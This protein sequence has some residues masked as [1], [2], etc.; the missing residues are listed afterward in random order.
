MTLDQAVALSLL[1]N[2]PRRGLTDRLRAGDPELMERAA[3]LLGLARDARERAAR[4]SI[5]V[6]AWDDER[7]PAGLVAI[8]DCPPALWYR[9]NLGCLGAVAVAIVGSRAASHVSLETASRLAA[10]LASRGVVVVSGLARGVDSAAHR[11]AL[12]TGS[13]IAVLGSG[14]DHVY[15]AEHTA[16]AREIETTGLVLSEYPPG[17]GPLPFR[18]PMRN[19]LI[20][21]LS[22]AVVVI[23]AHEKSGSLITAACAMDQ[24][25]DVMAVPGTVLGGRNRGG[26]SLIR[27]GAKIVECADDILNELGVIPGGAGPLA[28]DAT[29][30]ART[31]SADPVLRRMDPG[32]PYDLDTLADASGLD[33]SRLLTRLVD[34]ELRG[35]IRRVGGGCFMRP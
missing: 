35:L 32:H 5:H 17:T 21:G 8:N 31:V 16:L 34:L 26:H 9:G 11:G 3:P 19:R 2:L 12:R 24:G 20:S 15:P 28:V 29:A 6:I 18:F 25:R 1:E 22:R 4:E 27:D 30:D 7:M 14:V 23:E 10:D 13:T 33:A